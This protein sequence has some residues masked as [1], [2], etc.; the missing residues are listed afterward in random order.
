MVRDANAPISLSDANQIAQ[1]I[2]DGN[3]SVIIENGTTRLCHRDHPFRQEL[4]DDDLTEAGIEN[5]LD[6]WE[7]WPN[8][9]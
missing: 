3:V 2:T 4:R 8:V 5:A 6:G 1:Q 7:D 9:E